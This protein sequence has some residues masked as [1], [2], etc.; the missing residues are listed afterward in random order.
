MDI[1]GLVLLAVLG[2]YLGRYFSRL[3]SSVWLIG[4]GVPLL[5]LVMVGL[6]RYIYL[7]TFVVPFSWV[8]AGR[9]EYVLSALMIPM[10]LTTPLLRLPRKLM[11][12]LLMIL[13]AVAVL[14]YS[15]L[16]IVV[17]YF[18]RGEQEN[19]I[20]RV[21]DGGYF[22][23]STVYNC[24]PAAAATALGQLGVEASEGK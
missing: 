8:T 21:L 18:L 20:S 24:G 3:K 19:L 15:I 23:Q 14:Y 16:P 7:L 22:L 1:A 6:T 17:P 5:F 4:F 13:L 2:V 9:L 10:L 12:F 11:R